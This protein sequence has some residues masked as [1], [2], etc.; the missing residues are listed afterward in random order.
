M[1][2]NFFLFTTLMIIIIIFCGS[3]SAGDNQNLTTE[4]ENISTNYT[5]TQLTYNSYQTSYTSDFIVGYYINTNDPNTRINN[6]DWAYLKSIG[7]TDIYLRTQN[8][9]NYVYV[10]DLPAI[11]SKLDSFGLR[12]HAWVFPEFTQAA[13]VANYGVGL[14]VD[15]E[16]YDMASFIPVLT[17]MRAE[18]CNQIFSLCVKAQ[19]WDGNQRYDLLAPLC[20]YIVPM[21]YTGDYH[22]NIVDLAVFAK[23]QNNKYPGK[24][25]IALESYESDL[26]TVAKSQSKILAEINAVKAYSKGVI[27]FRLSPYL[28]NFDGGVSTTDIIPPKLTKT[29]PTN[30]ATGISLTS[31]ITITFSE[32]ITSATNYDAICITNLNT[33]KTVSIASKTISG[34]ILTITQTNSR[35]YGN[36]YQVY[37][38]AGA[39][40]DINGNILIDA[41]TFQFTTTP[42]TTDTTPPT[43]TSTNPANNTTG[44]SLTTPITITFSENITTGTN[45]TGIYVKNTSTG[46]KVSITK[47]INNNTLTI[48]QNTSRLYNTTY[49]VYIPSGAVK[50]NTGN[51]LTTTYSYN[52]TTTPQTTDTTP[53]TITSTNPA[54]NTTGISLT[55]PITITFSENI[56]TGTNYTGIYIKNLTTGNIVSI[57]SKTISGKTLTLKMTYSRL[58]K[59]TYMV[60]LPAGAVKDTTGNSLNTSKTFQ[61]K[62]V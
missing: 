55:T 57:A 61:F 35:L 13:E 44:I 25:I 7:V 8:S 11:K 49:Q 50:D 24:F 5:S 62:T 36:T 16:T 1:R 51:T 56:T 58:S 2:N 60:Y 12:L 37:I 32:N 59:N 42:Q 9:G 47:T 21:C 22:K 39:I 19:D 17:Q 31:P 34:N 26:N 27:L 45:Y 52:F 38:P 3:A 14:H 23:N 20:D 46:A 41:Y 48:T 4:Q 29:S 53:P 43:I 40:K 18:T 28:S 54:N 6:I 15:V 33:G 30:N 10:S